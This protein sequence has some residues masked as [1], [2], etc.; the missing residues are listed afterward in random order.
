MIA[1]GWRRPSTRRRGSIRCRPLGLELEIETGLGSWR[2]RGL[3]GRRRGTRGRGFARA[4]AGRPVDPFPGR[5]GSARSRLPRWP[6][7][8]PRSRRSRWPGSRS[9][10]ATWPPARRSS[11]TACWPMTACAP[12]W[13]S[14]ASSPTS[15]APPA[16]P[17][18]GTVRPVMALIARPVRV[19]DLPAGCGH[20]L[21]ADVPDGPAEPDRDAA[22]S[23]TATAGHGP[24]R[25]G[26]APS[27]A[28]FGCRSSATS[29]WT[30]SWPT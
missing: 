25:I 7:T 8:T 15:W 14:T 13:R 29:R 11:R 20:Q 1:A 12:G 16:S 27:S 21:R 4:Q 6:P 23:A 2:F 10:C 24:I 28:A 22:R 5:R 26:P 9:R 17:A 18:A 3:R 30:R 19:A